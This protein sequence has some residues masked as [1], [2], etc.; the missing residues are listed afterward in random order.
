M[1]IFPMKEIFYLCNTNQTNVIIKHG[2]FGING[3]FSKIPQF[4]RKKFLNSSLPTS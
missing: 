2:Q 1:S 3:H 4:P